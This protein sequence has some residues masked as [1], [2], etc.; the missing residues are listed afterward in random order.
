MLARKPG[1]CLFVFALAAV[2]QSDR[3]TITG[4]ISDPAG[5]VVA[6]APV[7]A[8]NLET[9]VVSQA[10]T[11][12]TGNYTLGQLPAGT[13]EINVTVAGFKKYTR[14]GLTV[15]ALQTLRVDVTLEIGSST[16]S[17]TVTEAAPLLKTESGDV[18][19]NVTS[20]RLNDLPLGNAGAVRN[21]LTVAQLIP[22]GYVVGASTLRVSGTPANSQQ[23]RIDGLDATYS[24]GASTSSFGTPSV[25]AI[26]EV[27][28]QTS[29][30]AA[31]YGLAGGAVFNLTMKSGTNQFHGSAYD[32]WVNEGLFARG[33]YTHIRTK[34]RRHDYGGTVG[35]PVWIPK[36][37]NGKD[38]TFFFFNYET[39]PTTVNT[40]T[41]T[42]TVPTAAYRIGDFSAATLAQGNRSLGTDILGRNIIQ[43]SIYNPASQRPASA[44]D[45][46]LVRDPFVGNVIPTAQLDPVAL[47]IQA[48]VPTASCPAGTDLSLCNPAGLTNNYLNPFSNNSVYLVPSIKID[49]SLSSRNK[50]SGFWGLNKEGTPNEGNPGTSEGFPQPISTFAATSFIT[51]TYRLNYDYTVTPT[52]LLHLGGGFVDSVLNMP[53]YTTDYDVTKQLG[54]KGPFEPHGFPNIGSTGNSLLGANN[55]GGLNMLGNS[56]FQGS[57]RSLQ[58][59]TNMAASLTWIKGNHNY[60]AGGELRFEGYPNFN[61]QR[62]NGL[63]NFSANETALPYLNTNS[64][65][66]GGVT[67]T[68]G[69]PYASFLLGMVNNGNV[70]R[71]AVARL[72]KHVVGLFVQDTWK[73]SR[74]FTLDYGL[75]YDYST[76][77]KEQYGRFGN[78]SP[79]T[80]NDT[81]GGHPGGVIYEATCGCNFSKNYPWAFGPR[82]GFAY[83]VN[84]KTVIRGGA[85]I[86]YNGTPNNNVVTRQV[87]SNNIFSASG[88]A[89]GSM[90][91]G[92]GLPLTLAQ[93]AYPNFSASYFPSGGTVGGGPPFLIDQNGG[94]P[95]RSYQWSIGAQR[96]IFRNLIIDA[97]YV[98]SRGIWW[99][100]NVLDNYNTFTPQ[101][102]VKYYGLDITNAADRAILAAPIGTAAAGKMQNKLPYAGFPT[103][104]T[105]AQALRPFPQFTSGLAALWAPLGSTWYNSLQFKVIKRLSHG[106]DFTYNFTYAQELTLGAEADSPGPFGATGVV[107]DVFNRNNNKYIS[108]YSRPLVSNIAV[109][110]VAPKWGKNKILRY[111][112][113]DWQI[114]AILTYASGTPLAVPTSSNNLATQLF[115]GTLMNR[116]PGEPLY[117]QDMNCHCFDPTKT[118]V[119]N[120]KAWVDPAPGTWGTS[121]GY[122]NDFRTQRRPDENITFG[123]LFQIK[124]RVSFEVRAEFTNAFNRT[125]LGNPTASNPATAPTCFVSGV[126]G[127]TGTCANGGAFASGYGFI[128][129]NGTNGARNGQIVARIRF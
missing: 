46:R 85:G 11:S 84:S 34:T 43:N 35:G 38:K 24:L 91:L 113:G 109:N 47:K 15:Q 30:F 100:A 36:V 32:Y 13:Y 22:G 64:I 60:K 104:Q 106:V 120:P 33:A 58:Q 26:Q 18:S 122:Y 111:V 50:I 75:R 98:G 10:G 5:A 41:A 87:T 57:Q 115:R 125:R 117:L 118:L 53:S 116:V 39:R 101:D 21:P 107:N 29:N 103:S 54:L 31:E 27:A 90:V 59:K 17:V 72:G 76:Y 73:I 79:T 2:A 69:L 25:D 9:G 102:L 23:V 108:V 16:E 52:M 67:G 61:I 3:G 94:R 77:Q 128:A 112:T 129:T 8:K 74:K 114:G 81:A 86:L 82:L 28:V 95:G 97:A 96:E 119:L 6:N 40:T 12:A 20:Q 1:L 89:Q 92:T 124:E 99:Q 80:P 55:T 123:R 127:T 126:S 62:T 51:K 71:P 7:E 56:G 68:I 121:T 88:F 48:L 70:S 49:H 42:Q 45:S 63:F 65:T 78:F 93:I 110:Y 83:Q 4:V 14:A 37:Y 44:T 66:S 19:H 105:V